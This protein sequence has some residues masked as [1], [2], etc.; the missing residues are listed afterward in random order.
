MTSPSAIARLEHAYRV[1]GALRNGSAL[2]IRRAYHHQA[3][4]WHPDKYAAGSP[5]QQVATAR[6]REINEAYELIKHAP[7]RFHVDAQP[8]P[9]TPTAPAPAR[10]PA[11]HRTAPV[12]DV[13]EYVVRFVAG[14]V[15]G[16]VFSFFGLFLRGS[17]VA[18]SIA[19]PFVIAT[20]SAILGDKFW[21][22]LLRNLWLWE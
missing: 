4:I 11:Q 3:R 1:L 14:L 22:F 10:A 19:V 15:F 2:E 16:A 18:L 9:S 13:L 5:Q 6:M 17:S 21:Y 12:P 8:A 20:L 7:L